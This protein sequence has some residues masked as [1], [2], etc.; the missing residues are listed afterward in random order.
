MTQIHRK[1]LKVLFK[2]VL[3]N[4]K[5]LIAFFFSFFIFYFSVLKII[6]F[7]QENTFD[8]VNYQYIN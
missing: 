7:R 8:E 5:Y 6:G 4:L 1:R 2:K 3:L